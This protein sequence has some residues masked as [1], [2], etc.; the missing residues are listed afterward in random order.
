MLTMLMT[1]AWV[2]STDVEDYVGNCFISPAMTVD[3]CFEAARR[4]SEKEG[5]SYASCMY[6]GVKESREAIFENG[7]FTDSMEVSG[8]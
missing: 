6:L 8:E 4:M 5:V 7:S 3:Q 1:C 2:W